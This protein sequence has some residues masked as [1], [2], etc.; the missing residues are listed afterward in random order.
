MGSYLIR[1][2]ARTKK[3]QRQP[4]PMAIERSSCR[5]NV[6]MMLHPPPITTEIKREM[7][8]AETHPIFSLLSELTHV[9]VFSKSFIA[10]NFQQR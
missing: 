2:Q 10:M 1:Q 8:T 7:R 9:F 4:M 3:N 6:S 5:L